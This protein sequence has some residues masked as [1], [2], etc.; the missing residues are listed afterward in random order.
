LAANTLAHIHYA[1]AEYDEAKE[2]VD[3]SLEL[4]EAIGHVVP[5]R[6]GLGLSL[7]VRAKLGEPVTAAPYA[8]AVEEGLRG[9]GNALL[10]VRVAVEGL[11]RIG[12]HDRAL[13]WAEIAH[14]RAAGRLKEAIAMAARGDVWQHVGRQREAEQAYQQALTLAQTIGA[15]STVAS[16]LIGLGELAMARGDLAGGQAYLKRATDLCRAHGFGHY[17]LRAEAAL[18]L[19][20]PSAQ[21]L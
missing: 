20:Q 8:D 17:L 14:E 5:A 6:M 16:V 13:R 21:P 10:V 15:H 2:W 19:S 4:G 9:G 1:R 18:Q 12:D 3:R 7:A 11:L